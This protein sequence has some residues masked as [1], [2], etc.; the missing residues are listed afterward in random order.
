[1]NLQPSSAREQLVST[2]IEGDHGFIEIEGTSKTGKTTLID[3]IITALVDQAPEGSSP[4]PV[5]LFAGDS[6]IDAARARW[7]RV[8]EVVVQGRVPETEAEEGGLGYDVRWSDWFA[9]ITKDRKEDLDFSPPALTVIFDD[10]F[11]EDDGS[12]RLYDDKVALVQNRDAHERT[13]VADVVPFLREAGVRIIAAFRP[14]HTSQLTPEHRDNGEEDRLT[15]RNEFAGTLH[16]DYPADV[17]LIPAANAE[18][19]WRA[20]PAPTP[21]MMVSPNAPLPS[22]EQSIWMTEGD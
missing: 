19:G 5:V 6:E 17:S 22:S 8:P 16:G 18:S 2:L 14:A 9:D 1:M 11:T 13:E 10:W 3:Q 15:V 12:L 21:P 7:E 20:A 4:P